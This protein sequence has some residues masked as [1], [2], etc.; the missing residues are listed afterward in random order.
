MHRIYALT[1]TTDEQTLSLRASAP[2]SATRHQDVLT[3]W[4]QKASKTRRNV[5]LQKY[6]PPAS[7]YHFDLERPMPTITKILI[8]FLVPG[9]TH[10]F[11]PFGLVLLS[12]L[13]LPFVFF[14]N[15]PVFEGFNRPA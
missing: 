12:K 3:L 5:N 9:M 7:L 15:A 6:P 2:M 8:P 10:S 4:I 13:T 14:V 11:S 1:L